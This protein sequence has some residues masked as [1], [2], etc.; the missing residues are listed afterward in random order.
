MRYG[1][2]IVFTGLFAV[3][4]HP[5]AAQE[6]T[7]AVLRAVHAYDA[8]WARRDTTMLRMLLAPSYHYEAGATSGD[9]AQTLAFLALPSYAPSTSTRDSIAATMHDSVATVTSILHTRG[10]MRGKPFNEDQRCT[11]ELLEHP[12]WL[13]TAERCEK[14]APPAPARATRRGHGQ[15]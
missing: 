14:I 15:P 6:T 3:V 4:A 10:T 11:L 12:V 7:A 13:V 2:M 5:V 1:R 9:R 8:A